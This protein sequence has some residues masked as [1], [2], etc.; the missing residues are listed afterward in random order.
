MVKE[1][2]SGNVVVK[3][4]EYVKSRYALFDDTYS[5]MIAVETPDYWTGVFETCGNCTRQA[6]EHFNL[7]WSAAKPI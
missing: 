6:Y 7:A 5:L 2:S 3:Y 4:S 1:E